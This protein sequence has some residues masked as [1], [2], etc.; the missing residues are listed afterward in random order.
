MPTIIAANEASTK[1][2]AQRLLAAAGDR[3]DRV[4]T[5]TAGSR[6]AFLVDD[7]LAAAIGTEDFVPPVDE[8]KPARKR[9][10]RKPKPADN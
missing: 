5:S 8:P 9:V 2:L 4:K 3:L 1:V 6:V 7:E 10:A